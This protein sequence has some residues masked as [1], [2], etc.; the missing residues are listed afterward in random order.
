MLK[1]LVIVAI[2]IVIYRY[3]SRDSDANKPKSEGNGVTMVQC[4]SCGLH[5]PQGE[6]IPDEGRWYCSEAHRSTGVKTLQAR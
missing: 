2:G 5:L 6:A 3:L 4:A 1:W